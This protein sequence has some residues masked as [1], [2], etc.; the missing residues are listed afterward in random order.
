ML[1]SNRLGSKVLIEVYFLQ[2]GELTFSHIDDR[3]QE[4]RTIW[5]TH[6]SYLNTFS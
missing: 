6:K 3:C 2:H 4:K 1:L 5:E